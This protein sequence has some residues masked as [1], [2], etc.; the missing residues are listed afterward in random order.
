[1]NFRMLRLLR[2]GQ[3]QIGRIGPIR[4]QVIRRAASDSAKQEPKK[5][6]WKAPI[7]GAFGC[8]ALGFLITLSTQLPLDPERMTIGSSDTRWSKMRPPQ[9]SSKSNMNSRETAKNDS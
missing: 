7:Y 1:M 9:S 5:S 4:S 6:P 2:L 3:I 8:Y